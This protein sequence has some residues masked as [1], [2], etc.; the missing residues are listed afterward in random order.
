ML[1]ITIS[2]KKL[3]SLS[4]E[5]AFWEVWVFDHRAGDRVWEK[6][7]ECTCTSTGVAGCP[8]WPPQL[9]GQEGA[10]LPAGWMNKPFP[11]LQGGRSLR[12]SL[13]GVP[14]CTGVRRKQ[15]PADSESLPETNTH[16]LSSW[17]CILSLLS[18]QLFS[19]PMRSQ[20]D[21]YVLDKIGISDQKRSA[22]LSC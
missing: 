21:L 7:Q 1:W 10:G 20:H 2:K 13:T 22:H 5:V 15:C 12:P 8:S 18:F 6:H 19:S 9:F 14:A 17:C 11:K 16:G 4:G 3:T